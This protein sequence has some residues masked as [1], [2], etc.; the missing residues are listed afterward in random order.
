MHH[1]VKYPSISGPGKFIRT[2]HDIPFVVGSV[3]YETSILGC[4]VHR[5]VH[6]NFEGNL[7]CMSQD[8]V[9]FSA[10]CFTNTLHIR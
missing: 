2:M 4:D 9:N 7:S 3:K 5:P 6:Y 10:F 1:E 8:T